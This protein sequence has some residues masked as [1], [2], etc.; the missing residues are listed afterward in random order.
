MD[1]LD[2]VGTCP[3]IRCF[4]C[5]KVLGNKYETF[6]RMTVLEGTPNHKVLDELGLRRMCCRTM[7]ITHVNVPFSGPPG[8]K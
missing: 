8:I 6:Y 1:S 2:L 5:Q 4:S 7:M 3:P